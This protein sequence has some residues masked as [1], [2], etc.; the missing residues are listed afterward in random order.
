MNHLVL[1]ETESH[2]IGLAGLELAMWIRLGLS[3]EMCLPLP[4][5]AGIKGAH[6][7]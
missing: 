1:I 2:G 4:P 7:A 5:S 3:S 6:L